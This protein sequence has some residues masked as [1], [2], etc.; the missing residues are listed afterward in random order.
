MPAT[1]VIEARRKVQ[2]EVREPT[3]CST[4]ASL[5]FLP[6]AADACPIS[7][8]LPVCRHCGGPPGL[9]GVAL[10]CSGGSLLVIRVLK[11]ALE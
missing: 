5:D 6:D 2:S 10:A 9:Q 1:G 7:P 8:Y 11:A 4:T 3:R